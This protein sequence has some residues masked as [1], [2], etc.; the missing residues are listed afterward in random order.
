MRDEAGGGYTS[1]GTGFTPAGEIL[2]TL[3]D[4]LPFVGQGRA[5]VS[6]ASGPAR[7]DVCSGAVTCELETRV[8][9]EAWFR[10]EF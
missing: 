4:P 10:L 6:V 2:L 3:P 8:E 9:H 5:V 1:V 7:V